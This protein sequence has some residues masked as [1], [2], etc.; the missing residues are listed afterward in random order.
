MHAI[1]SK[2]T[3]ILFYSVFIIKVFVS[4]TIIKVQLSQLLITR[5]NKI[6]YILFY[7]K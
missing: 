5:F 3:Y 7:I 1:Q 6:T 4:K 2:L